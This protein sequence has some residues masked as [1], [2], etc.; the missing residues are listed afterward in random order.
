MRRFF[1]PS[2]NRGSVK[3]R[4]KNQGVQSMPNLPSNRILDENQN[5]TNEKF[6]SRTSSKRLSMKKL[7]RTKSARRPNEN[8]K[9]FLKEE[10]GSPTVVE[11]TGST[12]K[13][14]VKPLQSS[15]L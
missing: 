12:F 13:N 15:K 6:S 14:T 10:I 5:A 9:K 3:V 1:F 7:R 8:K 4:S 11:N 2:S